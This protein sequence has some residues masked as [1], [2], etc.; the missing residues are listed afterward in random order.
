M[1]SEKRKKGVS[2]R[3]T[4]RI[5]T[6]KLFAAIKHS[7]PIDEYLEDSDSRT[8][9]VLRKYNSIGFTPL[10]Y[11][12]VHG[13]Y[14]AFVSI[15]NKLEALQDIDSLNAESAKGNNALRLVVFKKGSLKISNFLL[16]RV[17]TTHFDQQ[18]NNIDIIFFAARFW[19]LSQTFN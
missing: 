8:K 13:N 4:R 14:E 18:C 5:I 3:R 16:D 17:N 19:V 15:Y 7:K 12:A 6:D 1:A 2:K 9:S 10:L 11:A